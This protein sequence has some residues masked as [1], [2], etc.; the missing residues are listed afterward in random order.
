MTRVSTV[1]LSDPNSSQPC[2]MLLFIPVSLKPTAVVPIE[3]RAP[4]LPISQSPNLTN[5]TN[6]TINHPKLLYKNHRKTANLTSRATRMRSGSLGVWSLRGGSEPGAAG[7]APGAWLG[8]WC[9]SF[10]IIIIIIIITFFVGCRAWPR[11]ARTVALPVCRSAAVLF[12]FD[13]LSLCDVCCLC[14]GL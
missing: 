6:L 2:I 10:A 8:I 14:E 3:P 9:G 11:L 7:V 13:C 5:L 12:L 4:N 1:G